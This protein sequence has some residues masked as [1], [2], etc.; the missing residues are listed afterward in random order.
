MNG[1]RLD[2]LPFA[3]V[4]VLL[5]LCSCC[6]VFEAI[7]VIPVVLLGNFLTYLSTHWTATSRA[8]ITLVR[9]DDPADATFVCCIP[10]SEQGA[11]KAITMTHHTMHI[12][13]CEASMDYYA[14]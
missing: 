9:V 1:R 8:K 5:G 10:S 2:V 12:H 3:I 4:Y 11:S 13:I 6:I 14:R 7:Y